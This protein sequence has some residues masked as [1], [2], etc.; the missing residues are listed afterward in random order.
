MYAIW[1]TPHFRRYYIRLTKHAEEK[2]STLKYFGFI[3]DK[4]FVEE[5]VKNPVQKSQK[6]NQT[7]VLKPIDDKLALRVVYEKRGNETVV[8]TFYPVKRDRYGI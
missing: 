8:I 2:F 3:V 4:K 6:E 7:L 5:A 1:H